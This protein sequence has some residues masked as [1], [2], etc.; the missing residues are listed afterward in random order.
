MTN[1]QAY[2]GPEQ[3]NVANGN[4]LHILN[5]GDLHLSTPS[6]TFLLKDI[7]HVPNSKANLL[8]VSCHLIDHD[9]L[10]LFDHHGFSI[11]D[12][13]TG[14]LLCRDPLK[15]SLFPLQTRVHHASYSTPFT[16]MVQ[17]TSTVAVWHK[18]LGHPSSRILCHL[19]QNKVFPVVSNSIIPNCGFFFN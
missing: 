4:T 17:K 13:R 16:S 7:L 15:G 12:R 14:N 3:I 19:A 11:K 8:S 2:N 6:T 18:R 9:I 1:R 10:F 5:V